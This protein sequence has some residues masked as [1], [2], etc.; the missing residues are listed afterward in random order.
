MEIFSIMTI[1]SSFT[2]IFILI[3]KEW[4]RERRIK[5]LKDINN[6][7]IETMANYEMKSIVG[8]RLRNHKV[9]HN[10]KLLITKED[11]SED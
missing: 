4:F 1:V 2:V 9:L 5:L 3:I 11:H 10:L 7:K 8:E 6:T